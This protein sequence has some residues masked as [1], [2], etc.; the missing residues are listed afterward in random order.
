MP[1]RMVTPLATLRVLA[2]LFMS[3]ILTRKSA[4]KDGRIPTDAATI[5]MD[6]EEDLSWN[7]AS[8]SETL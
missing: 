8:V 5:D 4:G 1:V 6:L 7:L 2:T 3:C